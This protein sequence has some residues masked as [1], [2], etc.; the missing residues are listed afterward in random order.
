MSYAPDVVHVVL[1]R[2]LKRA[3]KVLAAQ[4]GVT[5]TDLVIQGVKTVLDQRAAADDQPIQ[6]TDDASRAA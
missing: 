2:G 1:P 3:L 5:M 6:A 4:T